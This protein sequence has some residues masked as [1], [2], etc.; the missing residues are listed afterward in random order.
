M[1]GPL[2]FFRRVVL[3]SLLCVAIPVYQPVARTH[4]GIKYHKTTVP[5]QQRYLL[6]A[7]LE[8]DDPPDPDPSDPMV[9]EVRAMLLQ[10]IEDSIILRME[11][12]LTLAEV[13]EFASGRLPPAGPSQWP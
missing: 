8:V 4:R 12:A 10:A 2:I 3:I 11:V 1:G 7:N 13:Q 9:E 6:V 5:K